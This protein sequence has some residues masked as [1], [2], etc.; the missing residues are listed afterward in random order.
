MNDIIKFPM[1]KY[2]HMQ[3]NDL[4]IL[5]VKQLAELE[6]KYRKQCK[7]AL[8]AY[9][10]WQKHYKAETDVI[11]LIYGQLKGIVLKQNAYANIQAYWIIRRDFRNC[12]YNYLKDKTSQTVNK[13][14]LKGGSR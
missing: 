11:E 5:E 10:C 3:V 8:C 4:E 13:K 7:L 9:R 2:N 14:L 12:F 1:R 6:D